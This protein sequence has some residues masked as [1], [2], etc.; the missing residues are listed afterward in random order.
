MI[1]AT[2]PSIPQF[3]LCVFRLIL[4]VWIGPDC[5]MTAT[6]TSG[7][8]NLHRKE[9]VSADV[10]SSQVGIVRVK[11]RHKHHSSRAKPPSSFEFFLFVVVL[12][13]TTSTR[14]GHPIL[15]ACPPPFSTSRGCDRC[16]TVYV[17]FVSRPHPNI[18]IDL[19]RGWGEPGKERGARGR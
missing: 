15:S 9:K 8:E 3:Y 2:I 4:G 5:P 10:F 12:R 11:C 18:S 17:G 6:I 16:G 7:R 1:S 13:R 19:K 14:T